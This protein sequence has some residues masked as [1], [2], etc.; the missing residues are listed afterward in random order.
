MVIFLWSAVSS[1]PAKFM[2]FGKL[3]IDWSVHTERHVDDV[4]TDNDVTVCCT[5]SLQFE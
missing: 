2:H 3:V 4:D 1:R 5:V